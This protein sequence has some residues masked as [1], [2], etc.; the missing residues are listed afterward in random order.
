MKTL[1]NIFLSI[2][3]LLTFNTVGVSQTLD[4]ENT[5]TITGKTKRGTLG[6]ASFNASQRIYSLVYVTKS[7]DR[8][9][10]EIWFARI[11]LD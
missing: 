2:C 7:N 1:L 8:K 10:K 5:Y 6:D 11:I 4:A 3:I 9:G